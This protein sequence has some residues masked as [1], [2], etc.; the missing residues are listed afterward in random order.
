MS[1]VHVHQT[2]EFKQLE[3]WLESQLAKM[4]TTRPTLVYIDYV[5]CTAN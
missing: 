3:D 2:F 4:S 1:H 5:T